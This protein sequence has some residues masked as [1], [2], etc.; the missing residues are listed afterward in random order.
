MKSKLIIVALL[1]TGSIL[2]GQETQTELSLLSTRVANLAE[3][4]ADL[5]N[6]VDSLK[7]VVK[8]LKLESEKAKWSSLQKGYSSEQVMSIL[9]DPSKMEEASFG[10]K[11]LIFGKGYSGYVLLA[12]S[13][14]KYFVNQ[15][16]CFKTFLKPLLKNIRL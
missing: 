16:P 2:M 8:E 13:E 11:K 6:E 3:L 4:T 12:Y 9:G 7:K 5:M 15:I 1:F 10:Y 14:F